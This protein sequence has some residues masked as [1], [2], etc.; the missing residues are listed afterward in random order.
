MRVCMS[1][2][3][4][5]G[6]WRRVKYDPFYL[7]WAAINIIKNQ[8]GRQA[9]RPGRAWGLVKTI[10]V[11]V[12]VCVCVRLCVSICIVSVRMWPGSLMTQRAP[13]KSASL[14]LPSRQLSF[15]VSVHVPH[16]KQTCEKFQF[17]APSLTRIS[18]MSDFIFDLNFPNYTSWTFPHM[19]YTMPNV[20]V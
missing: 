7:G 4:W 11:L 15:V 13:L 16:E 8:A 10:W 19:W 5:E 17:P 18:L 9:S 1:V 12:G 6:E 2:C 20:T 14:H 3:V